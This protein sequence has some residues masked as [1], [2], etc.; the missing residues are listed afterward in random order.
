MRIATY[1]KF[2]GTA[3]C[4]VLGL[5]GLNVSAAV[6]EEVV[7]TAQKREQSL[8]DVGISVSA[9]SGEQLENLGVTNTVDITQ[10]IPGMQL[11]TFSPAFTVFSLRG[12]SQNNFQD[13]LEA[14]VAVYM[15]GAYVASMNAINTQLFDMERVEVLRGPQ[16]TLYGRNTTGGLVHYITR[17]ATD[18]EFNGYI[19]GSVGSYETTG[20]EKYSVEAAAGGALTDRVRGRLAGR[21]ET[22][23]GYTEA[24][25]AFGAPTAA[26]RDTYGSNGFSLRGNL[27]IDVTNSAT[28]DLTVSHAEDDDV[29]TGQYI[30]SLA[31]FD[32]ATGLGTFDGIDPATGTPAV[33]PKETITG[34]V[35][36]HFS[37]EDTFYERK[38][39]SI[40]AQLTA[41]MDNGIE[42]VGITNWMTMNKFY[43]EDAG[44]GLVFFPYNTVND[45]TQF[46][47]ELRF[48]GSTD[49]M[50]W[51]VG[52]YYLDMTWD[53][54]QSVEG[55]A[56]HGGGPGSPITNAAFTET[57]GL[58]DSLNISVFGQVEYDIAPQWTLIGGLRYSRDD[59]NLNMTQFFTDS[60]QG[61]PRTQVL[62]VATDVAIPGID[63]IDYDDV[64]ARAQINWKPT[65]E[66]LVYASF[67]RGIKG[68]NWSLDPLGSIAAT[69]PANLKHDEEVL[70]AYELGLKT[71]LFNGLTRLNA[72][73]YYYDYDDYQAFS[74]AGLTPQVANSDAESFGGEIEVITSPIDGLD[75]MFG[76]AF[77]DSE[78]DAVPDVFGGTVQ[79][80]FPNAPSVSLNWLG[81]YEWPVMNGRMAVQID[82]NWNDDQFLEGSNSGVSFE[83]AYDVWNA[84]ISYTAA[85]GSWS[86]AVW[87]KNFTDTEYRLYNLDLGLLGFIEQVY[88]PPRQ[89]GGTLS[90]NW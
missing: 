81:R 57:F 44:G 85:D 32:P 10:Q 7:V 24:G 74:I 47:Q 43:L 35:H 67:S 14:P 84:R 36:K 68:G 33:F 23:D 3:M 73:A 40:S 48:S 1:H 38:T 39:T 31:G 5:T 34:D 60:G 53:T 72:S 75:L 63:R 82:G 78:V 89:I 49:R 4:A 77:I 88:A 70:H 21:W 30:V 79:A 28:L 22:D 6:L 9:F 11:F 41:E 55:A 29:P 90:Y 37:D 18:E 19:Q 59:K 76:A 27:Q 20:L 62:N 13:N 25:S 45:Y 52:A 42:F 58:V 15:D 65:E 87:A 51:Q 2:I 46:S 64:A 56:I 16:G 8:Q 86:A 12:V 61:I 54:F 83:E 69:S 66:T 17:K 80:E 50:R 26:G 71:S